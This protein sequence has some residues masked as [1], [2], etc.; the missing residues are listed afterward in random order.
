MSNVSAVSNIKVMHSAPLL[1]KQG[2]FDQMVWPIFEKDLQIS[3]EQ[4]I[5]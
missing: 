5:G 3:Q 4:N 1:R 2:S